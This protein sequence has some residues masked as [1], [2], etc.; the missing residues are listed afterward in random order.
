ESVRLENPLDGERPWLR[1]ALL[2]GMLD[3]AH[4]NLG[5]GLTDLALF[6]LGDVFRAIEGQGTD[7]MP[8]IDARP[9]DDVLDELDRLPEQPTHAA[10]LLVGERVRKQPGRAAERFGIADAIEAAER[11]A[12]TA[13]L[14]LE[15]RQAQRDWLHPGRG[16]ELLVGET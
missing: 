9:A 8:G 2:P 11:I 14:E 4:R 13:G 16:A 5:R 3:T 12:R 15:V 7:T 1:T 10:V 6:E